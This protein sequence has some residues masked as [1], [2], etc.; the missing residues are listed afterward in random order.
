[1]QRRDFLTTGAKATGAAL[2]LGS[3]A[4]ACAPAAGRAATSPSPVTGEPPLPPAIAALTKREP[5]PAITPAEQAER[6]ARAQR[7]MSELNVGALFI[8]SGPSLFYFTGVEW[9]R[10]ERTFGMLLPKSGDA[11]LIA[12]SFEEQRAGVASGGRFPIRTWHE[13]ESPFALI[14]TTLRDMGV[15]TGTVAVD[16]TA[17]YFIPRGI[18]AAAPSVTVTDAAPITHR[19][20]GVKSAA[21]IALMRFAN[22][23]TLEAFLA[24]FQTL[25]AGITQADLAR[26]V[27]AAMTRLGFPGGALVLFGESSAYPHGSASPRPLAEG[28]VVL[29]DGGLQVHGYSSDVTRTVT[30]GAP[31]AE[32]ARVYDVVHRAQSAALAAAVPGAKCGDV[33]T[34]ARRVIED[35]GFGPADKFFTHRLGHGIGLEGHE[36][37]YLVHGSEIVLKPGM[38]FSDEP[39][40]YQYGKF[41]VRLEDVIV[42]TESGAEMLTTQAAAA[43]V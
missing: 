19:L 40:I 37:P 22:Q 33:D 23:I 12:P 29:V 16:E 14:A 11:V 31:P 20:R 1:M 41:G 2:A 27:S 5:P 35:A 36:W 24:S 3:L 9:G 39:G 26:T 6:R 38:S 10:S 4:T 13:Y 43:L 7:L 18:A 32:V 25:R 42:I 34:A 8:E 17:R 28:D 15:A 21:E 30:H